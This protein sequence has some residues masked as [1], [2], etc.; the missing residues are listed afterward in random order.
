[1]SASAIIATLIAEAIIWGVHRFRAE[2]A[3]PSRR[4]RLNLS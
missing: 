3:R 2:L 4:I 1:M